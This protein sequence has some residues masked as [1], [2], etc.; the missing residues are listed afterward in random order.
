MIEFNF[1][2]I[3]DLHIEMWKDH[4]IV[5]TSLNCIVAGNVSRDRANLVTALYQLSGMYN[6]VFYIDGTIEHLHYIDNIAES[7]ED[8]QDLLEPLE[9]VIYMHN[10]VV[11]ADGIAIVSTNGWWD[12]KF[13]PAIN[14]TQSQQFTSELLQC[15]DYVPENIAESAAE[16]YIYLK[17]SITKLQ[18]FSDVKKIVIVTHTVPHVALIDHDEDL[19]SSLAINMMGNSTLTDI[20]D[21]DTHN[22]VVA[23]CFGHYSGDID[24]TINDVRYVSNARGVPGATHGSFVYYPKPITV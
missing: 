5:P 8:M 1:D 15:N 24:T 9:N 19:S 3:S 18:K 10:N 2:L 12:Y 17:K 22:K 6:N 13:D 20:L 11:V 7:Y 23:W 21:N 16:D 4:Q 14:T